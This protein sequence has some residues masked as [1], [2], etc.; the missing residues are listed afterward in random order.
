MKGVTVAAFNM[1]TNQEL[2][3]GER[4]EIRVDSPAHMKEYFKNPVATNEYFYKDE[5]GTLWGCTGDI[6][7]VDEEGFVYILG[8]A[9]DTYKAEDGAVVYCFDVES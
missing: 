7:Y 1:V 9:N 5:N 4:G 2:K 8:R 6:G 3:Y